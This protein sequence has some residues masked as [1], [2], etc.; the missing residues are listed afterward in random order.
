[1]EADAS[2]QHFRI[3]T[4]PHDVVTKQCKQPLTSN[5]VT[6]VL[7]GVS[8]VHK[9]QVIRLLGKGGFSSVYLAR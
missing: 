5:S 9:Y 6:G 8:F 2:V 4:S 1:M 3:Q 7:A